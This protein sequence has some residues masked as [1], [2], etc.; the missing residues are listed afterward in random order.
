MV[1]LEWSN[2]DVLE[3]FYEV[4]DLSKEARF[5]VYEEK[6]VPKK[7]RGQVEAWANA[8]VV[9][10]GG[11]MSPATRAIREQ[12]PVAGI[13]DLEKEA[14]D[15]EEL[16][17]ARIGPY[18]LDQFL[19]KGGFGYVFLGSHF[20]EDFHKEVAIKILKAELVGPELLRRFR[21]ERVFLS[22]LAHPNITRFLDGGTTDDGRLYFV[23]EYV[24]GEPIDIYCDGQELSLDQRLD[25]FCQIASAVQEVHRKAVIHRDIKASNILVTPDGVCKLLDFGIARNMDLDAER[26]GRPGPLTLSAASPEQI[27]GEALTTATDI[28]SLGL[29]LYS[30]LSGLRAYE[31]PLGSSREE[32]QQV[33]CQSQIEAPSVRGGRP[34]LRG[35][36][37]AIVLKTLA[38]DPKQRYGSVAQL[39]EDIRRYQRHEPV[40]ARDD[41]LSYVLGKL[42]RRHWVPLSGL[43]LVFLTVLSISVAFTLEVQRERDRALTMKGLL[44]NVLQ[45][46]DPNLNLG[47]DLP[48]SRV[49]DQAAADLPDLDVDSEVKAELMDLLGK[50]YMALGRHDEARS[51]LQM[52]L[53]IREELYPRGHPSVIESYQVLGR[54]EVEQGNWNPA[55]GFG[56]EGLAIA[57]KLGLVDLRSVADIHEDLAEVEVNTGDLRSA[58]SH[59]ERAM[60]IRWKVEDPLALTRQEVLDQAASLD[61]LGAV[62]YF[63][64]NPLGGESLYR[65][66]L[67]LLEVHD[68]ESHQVTATLLNNLSHALKQQK[69]LDEALAV[70]LRAEAMDRQLLGDESL[71]L[72]IRLLGIGN[73]HRRQGF[74]QEAL[75]A[76]QDALD[77]TLEL[78]DEAHPNVPRIRRCI[79]RAEGDIGE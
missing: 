30:V 42:M 62:T 76:C 13:D 66:A 40:T 67:R 32:V 60:E 27:Q 70:L 58:R 17:G 73:L 74:S 29:I 77:M 12:Q 41:G 45:L 26:R 36:L 18:Q 7:A 4:M 69:R 71:R 39:S 15:I 33:I 51:L 24:A 11:E 54:L 14:R 59:A 6:R 25:L 53:T 55:K 1:N 20:E 21:Q 8:D 43:L 16:K 31:I 64:G 9:G 22:D 19:G 46:G 72:G 3:L 5:R 61:L 56:K 50:V 49:I 44:Q 57:K 65:D 78:R 10:Q 52:S 79:Q 47:E 75:S 38:K 28:Y 63:E 2:D 37:D 35:D 68:V 48:L 23:M 34:E